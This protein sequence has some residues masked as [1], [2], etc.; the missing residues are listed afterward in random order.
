M[1][2]R[3]GP[4]FLGTTDCAG[5]PLVFRYISGRT[6]NAEMRGLLTTVIELTHRI[7]SRGLAVNNIQ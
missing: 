3:L 5:A 1:C 4:K 7:T 6:E 2:M